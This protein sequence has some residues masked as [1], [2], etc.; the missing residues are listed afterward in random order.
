[1]NTD[2]RKRQEEQDRL[3]TQLIE[4]LKTRLPELETL[5]AK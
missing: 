3:T 1:M 5:L 4:A 2:Y